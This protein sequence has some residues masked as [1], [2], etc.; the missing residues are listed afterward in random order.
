MPGM[1][2]RGRGRRLWEREAVRFRRAAIGCYAVALPLAGLAV[3]WSR[4]AWLAAVAVLR[5]MSW[6]DGRTAAL[7]AIV[8]TVVL[9]AGVVA[10]YVRARHLIHPTGAVA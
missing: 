2:R 9:Q 10:G 1:P 4:L 7:S 5:E 6:L 3:A 8:A